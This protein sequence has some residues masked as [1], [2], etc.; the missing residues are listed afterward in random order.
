MGRNSIKYSKNIPSRRAV[1]KDEL[2]IGLGNDN[3]GPTNLTDYYAGIDPP[4]GGYVVYAINAQT[5]KPYMFIANTSNDLIPIAR[6]LG[7][8]FITTVD[9]A[10]EF[11][12]NRKNTTLLTGP[13][14]V[15]DTAQLE[16]NI[17]ASVFGSYPQMG[18]TFY[19]LADT[20][21]TGSSFN[22]GYKDNGIIT[23]P[24]GAASTVFLKEITGLTSSYSV[25]A[26]FKNKANSSTVGVNY[27]TSS[28][29]TSAALSNTR[30][31][32]LT[33]VFDSAFNSRQLSQKIYLNGELKLNTTISSSLQPVGFPLNFRINNKSIAGSSEF[34]KV[35]IY[36]KPLTQDEVN[37]NYY[38]ASIVT[39]NL[40]FAVD[41]GNLV[42]Y[43]SGSTTTYSLT[44]S[45]TGTLVNGV[46]YDKENGGSWV[47]DGVDDRINVSS[48][49]VSYLTVDTWVYRTSTATNQGISRRQN[50]WAISQYNGTLQVAPGTD[51]DF[52][53]TGYTIPLNTWTHIVYTYSGTNQAGSQTVY[54]NGVAIFS[55]TDGSGPI[56]ATGNAYRIGYDDNG[57]FWGG[58]IASNQIY[59]RAL[60]ATEVAQNF[61]AQRT[62][63]GI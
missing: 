45:S 1:K 18:N 13:I 33:G 32:H 21:T 26:V 19:N 43:E 3:Y 42:S 10:I 38:G 24:S 9:E 60:T 51:W 54:I 50:E 53:N 44:G 31:H 57:W 16:G 5:Q 8:R 35:N 20:N 47:F 17:D 14:E 7:N 46:G 41:A 27:E 22:I 56:S 28:S 59:N 62:R 34:Q 30:F 25:T 39:D 6:T 58:K 36:S 12:S 15:M 29:S 4:T 37:K 2:V 40:V 63:F 52:L 48:F 61:T 49:N 23:F 55:A 11:I